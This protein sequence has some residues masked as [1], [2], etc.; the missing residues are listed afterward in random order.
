MRGML[1]AAVLIALCAPAAL[2]QVG[3][4]NIQ[5]EDDDYHKAELFVG[6]SHH[7]ESIIDPEG[8]DGFNA[9][10]TGNVSRYFGL[11]FDLAGHYHSDAFTDASV[12]NVLG[13]VQLKDNSKA[14]RFKP[15]AHLLGGVARRRAS[16]GTFGGFSDTGF[17]AVAGGGLDI[18]VHR[19]LDVRAGQVD[20]NLTRFSGEAG[21]G[22]RFG[23]GLVFH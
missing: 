4:G 13:G 22:F 2:A 7:R 12:Y 16:F 9:S 8:F 15:F 21:H 10:V 3:F 5:D 6:Y 14:A 20:Y 11:K 23:I 18:R 19:R 1:R 17:S